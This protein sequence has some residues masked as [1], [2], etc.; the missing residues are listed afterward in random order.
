MV[1]PDV[2]QAETLRVYIDNLRK[3]YSATSIVVTVQT[4]GDGASLRG[5]LIQG[6]P[7]SALDTL[8]PANQTK[9]ADA[10]RIA[11][12]TVHTARQLVSGRQ[13]LSVVVKDDTLGVR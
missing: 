12:R 1:R 10:Y 4:A 6:L 3:A 11:E 13:E 7:A 8:R 5:Q 2:P 9:R